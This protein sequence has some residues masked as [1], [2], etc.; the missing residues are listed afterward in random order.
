MYRQK[1]IHAIKKLPAGQNA[2][3]GKFFDAGRFLTG[4]FLLFSMFYKYN[5]GS[6]TAA[7]H[8]LRPNPSG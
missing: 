6:G 4:G 2:L 1:F 3:S 7:L 5:P 8:P